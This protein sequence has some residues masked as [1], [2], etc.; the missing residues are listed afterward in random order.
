MIQL[1]KNISIILTCIVTSGGILYSV[2][3]YFAKSSEVAVI[4]SDLEESQ[5]ELKGSFKVSQ[6]DHL[7][8]T[9]QQSIDRYEALSVFQPKEEEPTEVEKAMIKGERE[10]LFELKEQR[11]AMVSGDK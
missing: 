11:K 6:M 8:A 5:D 9:Q 4:K 3:K 2:D 1:V 7:I 10:Q